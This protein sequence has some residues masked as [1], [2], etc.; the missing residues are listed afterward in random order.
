MHAF[1]LFCRRQEVTRS[2]PSYTSG[3]CGS[4]RHSNSN[5]E[6]SHLPST[7]TMA[8]TDIK[9]RMKAAKADLSELKSKLQ[10]LRGARAQTTLADVA[11]R[12]AGGLG[13]IPRLQDRKRL[14]GHFGKV[15]ALSWAGDS[16]TIV[17]A[18]SVSRR[19]C[20][21]PGGNAT[22]NQHPCLDSL[23]TVKTE[24]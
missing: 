2:P 19:F 7:A 24:S 16:Q 15:Y 5:R 3:G 23:P 4:W 14:F 20:H 9:A 8:A 22:H 17:S 11:V 13:P 10:A 18:R 21:S 6:L 1:G 12:S